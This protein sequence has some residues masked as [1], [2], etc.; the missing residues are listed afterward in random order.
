VSLPSGFGFFAWL[1]LHLLIRFSPPSGVILGLNIF[2][3][4][5]SADIAGSTNIATS[6]P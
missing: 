4:G 5:L 2:T 1:F 3:D 6:A